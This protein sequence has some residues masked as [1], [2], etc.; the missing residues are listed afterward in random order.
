MTIPD[1]DD[2]VIRQRHGNPSTVFL[3]GT[4]AAPDQFIVRAR[5]QAVSQ[6]LAYARQQHARAWFAKGDA[7][8]VL[9]GTFRNGQRGIDE[10]FMMAKSTKTDNSITTAADR[11]QEA[12]AQPAAITRGEIAR[13]AYDLYL[14]RGGEHGHEVED[15]LQAE[16]DLGARSTTA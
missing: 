12:P 16:R 6:A 13:R 1:R 14:A 5:D 2:V 15:W 11:P 7:D 4:P 10:G 9:L 3:L 8:F